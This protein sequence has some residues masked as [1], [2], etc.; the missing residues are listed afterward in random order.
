MQK[1]QVRGAVGKGST[2]WREQVKRPW[3]KG[4]DRGGRQELCVNRRD[5]EALSLGR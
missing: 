3:A 2:M 4:V 5:G 1:T